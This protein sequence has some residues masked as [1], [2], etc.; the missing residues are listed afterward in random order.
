MFEPAYTGGKFIVM[1][2]E[3]HAIAMNDLKVSL[4]NLKTS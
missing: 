3:I 4:Y 2:D 1:N